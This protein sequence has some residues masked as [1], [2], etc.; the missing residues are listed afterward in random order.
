MATNRESTEPPS[1]SAERQAMALRT[2]GV[3]SGAAGGAIAGTAF[4]GPPGA[5]VGALVGATLG[6]ALNLGIEAPVKSQ[7]G[8]PEEED[9]DQEQMRRTS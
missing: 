4:G 8:D 3:L 9:G 6:T 1:T 2:G 5:A 7:T